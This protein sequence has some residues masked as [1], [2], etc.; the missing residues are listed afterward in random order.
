[1]V[2]GMPICVVM[3][4]YLCLY[5]FV[6]VGMGMCMGSMGKLIYGNDKGTLSMTKRS[7]DRISEEK[8]CMSSRCADPRPPIYSH[9]SPNSAPSIYSK[10]DD[11]G[12]SG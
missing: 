7:H 9:N 2:M 8:A 4:M 1:M 5:A 11:G 6:C 10:A 3:F 12:A